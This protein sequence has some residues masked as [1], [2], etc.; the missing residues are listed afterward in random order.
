[1]LPGFLRTYVILDTHSIGLWTLVMTSDLHMLSSTSVY[2]MY[3]DAPRFVD[4]GE[5]G[6]ADGYT[7]LARPLKRW[8]Y[9]GRR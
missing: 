4:S 5:Y 3:G 7:E 8:R 1:M 2:Y 6:R 9:R